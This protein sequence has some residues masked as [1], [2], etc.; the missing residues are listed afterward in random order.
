MRTMIV[1]IIA[2]LLSACSG[3][4]DTASAIWSKILSKCAQSDF[5]GTQYLFFGIS[6]SV[7]PGSGWRLNSDGT[8]RLLFT[9]AQPFPP[10]TNVSSLVVDNNVSSCAGN[11]S[12]NW[13]MSVALPFSLNTDSISADIAGTLRRASN[14]RVSIT[15][16]STDLLAEVPWLSAIDNLPAASLYKTALEQPNAVVAENAIKVTGLRAVFTFNNQIS[17]DIQAELKGR[18]FS[19]GDPGAKTTGTKAGPNGSA[20]AS[21]GASLGSSSS[22]GANCALSAGSSTP[23]SSTVVPTAGGAKL[24]IG[25]VSAHTIVVCATEPFYLL[26]SYGRPIL[27]KGF[28]VAQGAYSS[29]VIVPA[30]IPKNVRVTTQLVS[31]P[32]KK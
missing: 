1:A 2:V 8:I 4:S 14:V 10:G 13:D 26:A 20:N 18:T 9:L 17:G 3:G 21:A 32:G 7:G 22:H 30:K 6:N 25:V 19:V 11:S 28:G 5:V 24:H 12:T 27:G 29:G 31:Q 23:S 16:Y 15:G